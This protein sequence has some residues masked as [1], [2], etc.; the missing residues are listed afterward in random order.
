MRHEMSAFVNGK[1]AAAAVGGDSRTIGL[2]ELLLA[3]SRL[4]VDP[5][6]L[7]LLHSRINQRNLRNRVW[8]LAL[9][10]AFIRSLS[11][12]PLCS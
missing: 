3:F 12:P 4:N 7:R 9:H 5:H 11:S 1:A 10:S 8:R 6:G 2:S